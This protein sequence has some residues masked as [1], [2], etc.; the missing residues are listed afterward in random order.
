MTKRSTIGFIVIIAITFAIGLMISR[1]ISTRRANNVVFNNIP[2]VDYALHDSTSKYFINLDDM[3]REL[4][5]LPIV[6]MAE[7]TNQISMLNAMDTMDCFDNI[8]GAQHEDQIEDFAGE[9]LIFFADMAHTPYTDFTSKEALRD[10]VIYNAISLLQDKVTIP[11]IFILNDPLAC[12]YAAADFK[13]FLK[14]SNSGIK[15]ISIIDAAVNQA[16]EQIDTTSSQP[17]AIGVIGSEEVIASEGFQN[18]LKEEIVNRGMTNDIQIIA[19][20]YAADSTKLNY[21]DPEFGVTTKYNIDFT[22]MDSLFAKRKI[23]NDG[24]RYEMKAII[25]ANNDYYQIAE[26]YAQRAKVICPIILPE[27]SAAIECYKTLRL[28]HNLSM[29]ITKKFHEIYYSVADYDGTTQN[30]CIN[31]Q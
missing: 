17:F 28:D 25:I 12:T 3:D 15:V 10:Q 29:R 22:A 27:K 4:R 2:I 7:D 24:S 14:Q 26:E 13:S 21:F 8:T 9:H 31:Q 18:S 11:K 30:V 20:T 5:L 23:Q 16:F 19:Q 1:K 6:I